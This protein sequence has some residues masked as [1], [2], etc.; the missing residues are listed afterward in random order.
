MRRLA[1]VVAF[2]AVLA[3][4]SSGSEASERTLATTTTA[5]VFPTRA[6]DWGTL[7]DVCGPRRGGGATSG[8]DAVGITDDAIR[9][10]TVADAGYPGRPGL[11]QEL[12]DAGE[13][14]V[15]W[16]NAAGGIN[17]RKLL[18]T[19]WDARV[20][21]YRSALEAACAGQ[22]ALVG[23]GA[24]DDG[25][26]SDVGQACGLVDL[27]ATVAD[28]AHAGH[29]G[30][31]PSVNRTVQAVP[32]PADQV[33]V[34]AARLVAAA[35][36]A[37]GARHVI[38]GP[39]HPA[40]AGA[41]AR[42]AEAGRGLGHTVL[43]TVTYDLAGEADW[44]PI[45]REVARQRPTWLTFVGEPANA[46]ALAQALD[47]ERV[48]PDVWLLDPSLYDQSFLDAAG[49]AADGVLVSTPFVPLEEADFHPATALYRANVAA[50]EGKQSGLGLQSTSAWLLFAR[51]ASTCDRADDL[52]RACLLREADRVRSWTGGGLHAPTDPGTNQGPTCT[53]VLQAGGARFRR[54]APTDQDF[55]CDPAA[56]ED[57]SASAG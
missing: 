32:D 55:A 27:P 24:V 39:D 45:A 5:V 3:S 8:T 51:L 13:A 48:H 26:W 29:A 42:Q 7:R 36:P 37:A 40:M 22:F 18:L 9:V 56:Q 19:K 10:G 43:P 41:I 38:V 12:L 4:C 50:I 30:Q 11:H 6:G 54:W 23:G 2:L 25:A 14:F 47:E 21:A 34:G 20:D 33:P 1:V 46:A 35:Q 49:T 17:G 15:E 16:C 57:V 28:P 31:A 44:A 52:T 53:V